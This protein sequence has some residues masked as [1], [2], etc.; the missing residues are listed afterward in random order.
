MQI[1][2]QETIAA[3]LQQMQERRPKRP[4]AVTT[5]QPRTRA[6]G[7]CACRNCKVCEDNAR[8]ERVFNE[9]FADPD[10][11]LP[12]HITQGSSLASL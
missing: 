3:M 9:K 7:R 1:E 2:T 6:A 4:G 11:Y 10:Y 5:T 8:W 12:R